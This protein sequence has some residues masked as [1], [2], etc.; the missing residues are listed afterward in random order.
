M[1]AEKVKDAP[2]LSYVL[3]GCG[4]YSIRTVHFFQANRSSNV[5]DCTFSED[6]VRSNDN[7]SNASLFMKNLPVWKWIENKKLLEIQSEKKKLQN[8]SW[9][10]DIKLRNVTDVIVHILE[11]TESSEQNTE[12]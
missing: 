11:D 8:T 2:P 12:M 9:S 7:F 1:A 10:S 3:L 5:N 6:S 4:L